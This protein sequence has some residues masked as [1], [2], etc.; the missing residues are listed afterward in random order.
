MGFSVSGAAAIILASLFIALGMWDSAGTNSF[1]RVTEAQN[2]RTD[3]VLD[4]RNT[5][6]EIVAAEYNASGNDELSV[7][8]D[9]T[10]AAQ[11]SVSETD[12]FVDGSYETDWT[13]S[14]VDGNSETDLWLA[15][16]QLMI[17]VSLSAAPDRVKVV[18]ETAVADTNASV[19]D[20][21][22]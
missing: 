21:S 3:T 11:L 7:R 14:T 16:E 6:I 20:K 2:D 12:L 1:E 10:G 9:N 15:G 13:T 19:V 4:T 22:P 18:S 17:N 5:D 8:V